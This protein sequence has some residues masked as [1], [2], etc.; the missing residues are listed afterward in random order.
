MTRHSSTLL[1]VLH[2]NFHLLDDRLWRVRKC[3]SSITLLLSSSAVLILGCFDPFADGGV[4]PGLSSWVRNCACST[5]EQGKTIGLQLET[6]LEDVARVS[7]T[8]STSCATE[9]RTVFGLGQGLASALVVALSLIGL[10]TVPSRQES[11][12]PGRQSGLMNL[13]QSLALR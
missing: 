9:P 1:R 3:V 12:A 4:N 6:S 2:R 7:I 5:V 8:S 11:T 13:L 10:G